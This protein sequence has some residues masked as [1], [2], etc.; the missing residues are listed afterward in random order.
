M[1][2]RII[3]D[4]DDTIFISNPY[5]CEKIKAGLKDT[6]YADDENLI[7]TIE[8]SFNLYE[9]EH[10]IYDVDKFID[11]FNR[12]N[13]VKITKKMFKNINDRF[14]EVCVLKENAKEILE[15]LSKKYEIVALTNYLYD[16]QIRRLKE[17]NILKY[18][19]EIYA[20]DKNILKPNFESYQLSCGNYQKEECV[21]IGDSL[22]KDYLGAIKFGMDAI[23][24]DETNKCD[25]SYK[26][27]SNLIEI[28]KYL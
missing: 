13:T 3:F 2:K 27:I 23:L 6:P 15:Y 11:F 19:K 16:V 10:N 4:L 12:N 8:A 22:A 18:F 24:F 21:I 5:Y 14:S 1:I 7:K 17:S 26:K 9:K 28:K 20:G 25:S